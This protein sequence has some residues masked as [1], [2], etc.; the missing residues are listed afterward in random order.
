MAATPAAAVSDPPAA[1]PMEPPTW[2]EMQAARVAIGG[3][4][5]VTPIVPSTV[6]RADIAGRTPAGGCE[7]PAASPTDPP[8]LLKLEQLQVGGNFKARGVYHAVAKLPEARRREGLLTCSA[9]NTA[10]ALA[11]CGRHFGVPAVAVGDAGTLPPG[12]GRR[13]HVAR[14]HAPLDADGRGVCL[15]AGSRLGGW[16]WRWRRDR[17]CATACRCRT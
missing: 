11:L 15:H 1:V 12:E 10:R 5:R 13:V 4:I 3:F 16:R 6:V 2:A 14:R 7:A 9:G 17:R 8:V